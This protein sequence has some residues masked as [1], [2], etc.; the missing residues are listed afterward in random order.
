MKFLI[1]GDLHL[2]PNTPE[3]RLDNFEETTLRK[4]GFI[5]QTAATNKVFAILQPGDFTDSPSMPWKYFIK[6]V[7]LINDYSLP[8]VTVYGQHDLRYRNKGNTSLDGLA[9][10]CP[11]ITILSGDTH[12]F[13]MKGVTIAG[14]SYGEGLL[15]DGEILLIHKMFIPSEE[16]RI[17][18]TQQGYELTVPFL[19][20]NFFNLVVSGDNHHHFR[21]NTGGKTLVNCGTTFRTKITEIDHKPVCYIYDDD[22]KKLTPHFIPIEPNVFDVDK[23]KSKE[24]KNKELASFIEGLSQHK[25]MGLHFEDN[26]R[27][28]CLKNKIDKSIVEIIEE[29]KKDGTH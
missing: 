10:A 3:N 4:L 26:L 6:I 25:E 1:C 12:F 23:V 17:W 24:E 15:V 11:H 22:S 2:T 14:V 29:C 8:I 5:L 21:V 9:S 27:E 18:V 28:Y 13:H 19:K 20:K 16:E 7:E